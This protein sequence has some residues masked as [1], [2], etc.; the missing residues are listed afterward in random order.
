MRRLRLPGWRGRGRLARLRREQRN[1]HIR[2]VPVARRMCWVVIVV[3][4]LVG[5]AVAVLIAAELWPPGLAA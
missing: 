1:Q 3:W 5:A 4:A 2:R